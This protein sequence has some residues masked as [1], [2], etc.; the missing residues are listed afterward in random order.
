MRWRAAARANTSRGLYDSPAVQWSAT[1]FVEAQVMIHDRFLFDRVTNEWT[2]PRFLADLT[3]R[4]GGV[5]VVLLWHSYPNIGADDRNQFELLASLPGGLPGL[6]RLVADFHAHGVRVLLCFNPWD[7]GTRDAY[8]AQTPFERVVGAVRAVGADGFNGDQ[9]YGVPEGFLAAAGATPLVL[10]PEI[11]FN[12]SATGVGVDTMTWSGA[13]AFSKLP[14]PLTLAFKVLEQRHMVHVLHRDGKDRTRAVQTSWF[15]GAGVHSW[16]NVFG[17]WNGLTPRVAAATKA[18]VTFLR[19]F[20]P[21]VQGASTDWRPHAPVSTRALLFAS[22]FSNATHALWTVVNTDN[23]TDHTS[24]ATLSL[25][26]EPA[27][28][29]AYAWY[30]LWAA[31]P[32]RG[33]AC[34]GSAVAV[35]LPVERSGFGGLLRIKNVRRHQVGPDVGPTSALYSFA[36]FPSE[37]AGQLA[38]R[39]AQPHTPLAE[40]Q[41]GGGGGGGGPARGHGTSS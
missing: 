27:G 37:C 36:L 31:K 11:C 34:A 39:L 17:I 26:C 24:G 10:E 28:F 7:T 2:V 33:L 12:N 9:M 35:P 22:E 41:R 23:Q 6:K 18:V 5:D 30:D 13:F 29:G 19:A 14:A 21:L 15:N 1:A 38:S 32:L 25:P 8:A 16:E 20:G 4:Y 3:G 40:G